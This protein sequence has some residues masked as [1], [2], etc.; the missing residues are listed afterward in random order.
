MQFAPVMNAVIT[1]WNIPR[2]AAA[3]SYL[4][5]GKRGP[6]PQELFN[7]TEEMNKEP[8]REEKESLAPG[9]G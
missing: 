2:V 8:E 4:K 6:Q 9:V 5:N 1:W 3:Y 7:Y